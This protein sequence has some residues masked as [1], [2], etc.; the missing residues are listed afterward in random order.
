[1]YACLGRRCR[2]LAV[3]AYDFALQVTAREL[4]VILELL[5]HGR[6]ALAFHRLTFLP[7]EIGEMARQA[8]HRR[9]RASSL[10]EVG[11]HKKHG[12]AAPH[13]IEKVVPVAP[14]Q[15]HRFHT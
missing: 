7:Q 5:G 1:M 6:Q 13:S 4:G 2:P 9:I 14:S 3:E 12:P 11:T 15:L 8:T 10:P